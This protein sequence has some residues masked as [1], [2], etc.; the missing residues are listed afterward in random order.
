MP[1]DGSGISVTICHDGQFCVAY[2]ER[3]GSQG[4]SAARVILGAEPALP[5]VAGFVNSRAFLEL[6]YLPL[7]EDAAPRALA[8]NPKRRQREAAKAAKEP[9]S[10]TRSQ[11]ALQAALDE[12]KQERR[13]AGRR[14]R[15]EEAE[16][17]HR[18]RVE[19]RR[20]KRRGH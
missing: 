14:Q 17:R 3:W 15:S 1:D 13:A 9:A 2:C 19:K 18:Q 11:A 20:E 8:G 7:D 12:H 10:S 4:R 6:P 16:E 5:E